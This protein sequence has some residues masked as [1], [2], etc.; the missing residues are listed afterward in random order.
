MLQHLNI[1]KEQWKNRKLIISLSMYNLKSE[2][3]NHYLGLLWVIMIP[4]VQV[5]LYYVVFGLGLRGDR[6]DVGGVP[7]IV[8][9]ISGLFPWLFISSAIN[10]SA[11]AI[12]S[13]ISLVTKMKFPSSILITINIFGAFRGLLV[14]TGIVLLVSIF[15]GYSDPMNYLVFFYFVFAS[16]ALIFSIGLIM[17]TLTIIVR[18][19]KNVLQNVVRMFFFLTPIFWSLDEAN[20]LLQNLSSYNPFAYLVMTYR[21]A[22]VLETGPFYGDMFDHLYFWSL[23]LFLFYVGVRVHNRFRKTIVDYI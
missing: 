13:Q 14:T 15:N 2:F 17:S 1:L 12:Q 3:A 21:T 11:S 4:L 16:I 8:H 9:L 7:F 10:T 5:L 6:G 18:D 23:T 20:A 19:L 22:F